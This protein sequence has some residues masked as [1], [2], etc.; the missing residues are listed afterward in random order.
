VPQSEKAGGAT[1]AISNLPRVAYLKF[2][3]W[4]SRLGFRHEDDNL[5]LQKRIMQRSPKKD[6][7]MIIRKDVAG[8]ERM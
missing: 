7:R 8:N 4:P 5:I 3:A 2:K 6:A 1:K